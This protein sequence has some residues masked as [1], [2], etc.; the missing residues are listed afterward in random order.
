MLE[1]SVHQAASCLMSLGS[2]EGLGVLPRLGHHPLLKEKLLST[3]KG[4][5]GKFR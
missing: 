2:D 5:E 3:Q 1:C 4:G